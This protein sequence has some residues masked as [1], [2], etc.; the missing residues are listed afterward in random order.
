MAERAEI[1]N[2]ASRLA[3]EAVDREV[4]EALA[5]REKKLA[6][7]RKAAEKIADSLVK[8]IEDDILASASEGKHFFKVMELV[9]EKTGDGSAVTR[10][11]D[12]AR[13]EY[14]MAFQI[15]FEKCKALGLEPMIGYPPNAEDKDPS[16]VLLPQTITINWS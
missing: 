2:I 6:E 15:V 10:T 4:K 3:R 12:I 16:H 9:D 14:R 7:D 5:E 8:D 1:L 11:F 13:P